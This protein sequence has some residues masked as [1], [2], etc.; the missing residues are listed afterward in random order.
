MT[1]PALNATRRPSLREPVPPVTLPW[2]S[3]TSF[4]ARAAVVRVLPSI[5]TIIPSHPAEA[6]KIAPRKNAKVVRTPSNFVCWSSTEKSAHKIPPNK[7]TK[8]ESHLYSS[9]RKAMAPSLIMAPYLSTK[10]LPTSLPVGSDLSVTYVYVVK[11]SARTP[12]TS[13]GSA[14]SRIVLSFRANG[15]IVPNQGA[16]PRLPLDL[17][18]RAARA[19]TVH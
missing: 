19:P 9:L 1:E 12:P 16:A 10:G 13:A 18:A 6:D 14:I 2:E 15:A 8:T 7:T 5:A 11:S 4:P 3:F 17:V